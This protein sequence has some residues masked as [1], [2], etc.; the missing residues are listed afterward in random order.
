MDL[1]SVLLN[2]CMFLEPHS[3][4]RSTQKPYLETKNGLAVRA[5]II[6][7]SPIKFLSWYP[8]AHITDTYG[9]SARIYKGK[10]R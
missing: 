6:W 2:F 9:V 8:F 5:L 10:A 3:K 4:T 7:M 1:F